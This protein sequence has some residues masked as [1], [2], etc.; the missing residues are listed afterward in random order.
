MKRLHVTNTA[1]IADHDA[2]R[3][4]AE[5]VRWYPQ[6]SRTGRHRHPCHVTTWPDGV[7]V[8]CR[9]TKA[10]HWSFTV[11]RDDVVAWTPGSS[12][13]HP[14]SCT[15]NRRCMYGLRGHDGTWVPCCDDAGESDREGP[16]A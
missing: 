5:V 12:C 4:V 1:G 6:A 14:S 11:T 2:L 9:P 10:G 7:A 3:R 8:W 16:H 15:R 13:R